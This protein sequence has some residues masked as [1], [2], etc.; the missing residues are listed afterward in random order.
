MACGW[1]L[2][3]EKINTTPAHVFLRD[4]EELLK[5]LLQ[6]SPDLSY[7]HE[8]HN[9]LQRICLALPDSFVS[10]RM[11]TLHAS[12]L[13]NVLTGIALNPGEQ[14]TDWNSQDVGQILLDNVSDIKRR[15][16][17][18]LFRSPPV[19]TSDELGSAVTDIKVRVLSGFVPE[20]SS[21]NNLDIQALELDLQQDGSEHS[22]ILPTAS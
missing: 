13:C 22:T 12:M 7:Q 18:M 6:V 19:D 17:A 14:S 11:W 9:A 8:F 21:V 20:L 3:E 15:N 10:P 5:V 4:T 16:E 2:I 1:C